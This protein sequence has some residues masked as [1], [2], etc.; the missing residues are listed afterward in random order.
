MMSD[1]ISKINTPL[2]VAAQALHTEIKGKKERV[3]DV[4]KNGDTLASTIK[5]RSQIMYTFCGNTQATS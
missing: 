5:V 2:S 3:E 4:H 1:E